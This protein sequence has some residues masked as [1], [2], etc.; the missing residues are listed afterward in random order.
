MIKDKAL[1]VQYLDSFAYNVKEGLA[2]KAAQ[3][4]IAEHGEEAV[5]VVDQ[6]DIDKAKEEGHEK[7]VLVPKVTSQLLR[8]SSCWTA[9]APRI[10]KKTPREL[11]LEYSRKWRGLMIEGDMQTEF[12]AL[13]DKAESWSN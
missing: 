4:F 7:I 12:D 10:V 5:P 9:P 2:D 6:Y 8:N 3:E 11:L 1:D 13:I